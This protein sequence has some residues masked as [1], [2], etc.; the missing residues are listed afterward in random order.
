LFFGAGFAQVVQT[1]NELVFVT[2]GERQL[3]RILHLTARPHLAPAVRS[4]LG[5]SR[6]HWDGDTLI[7]DTTDYEGRFDFEFR[8]ADANLHL[9]E[10]FQ[11][12]DADTLVEE[13]TIDDPT[14]FTA[15][16]TMIVSMRR[17]GGR[18]F[19]SACHEGNYALGNIL[20]GARAEEAELSHRPK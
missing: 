10:R 5:D 20:S 9:M 1:S 8:G 12:V 16:W 17:V 18:L 2:G 19:E 7:V 4:S 3:R 14:A 6:A 11:L 15:Q 13:A